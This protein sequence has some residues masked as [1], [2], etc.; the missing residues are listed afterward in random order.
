[1]E[2]LLSVEEF[3]T[4][5]DDYFIIDKKEVVGPMIQYF[6]IKKK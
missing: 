4:I 2:M 6:L 5:L 3:D 1:M